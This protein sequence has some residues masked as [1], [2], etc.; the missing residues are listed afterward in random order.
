MTYRHA[1]NLLDIQ[2]LNDYTVAVA[3]DKIRLHAV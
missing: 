2:T 3:R 1:Q